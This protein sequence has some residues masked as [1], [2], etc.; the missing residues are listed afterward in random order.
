MS[1]GYSKG[2]NNMPEHIIVRLEI[3]PPAKK[4]LE[5]LAER[6][7]MTQVAMTS[8]IIEWFA[9][10]SELIQAAILGHYPPEIQADIAKLILSRMSDKDL[11]PK[12]TA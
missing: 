1:Q 12:R 8:R 7:G 11:R 3:T 4:E 9:G 10:Q 5:Q 6:S 2:S